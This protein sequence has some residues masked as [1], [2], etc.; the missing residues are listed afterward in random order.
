M[1]Q[2]QIPLP[3][4]AHICHYRVLYGDT[5]SGGV[6][7]YANYLRFFELSRTELMRDAGCTYRSL[8]EQ[9]M[10]LPVVESYVRYKASARYDDMLTIRTA[11]IELRKF[12]CRFN[13]AITR[14]ADD[15]LLVK[16]FTVHA[17][18]NREGSLTQFSPP[19]Y[20]LL[21]ATCLCPSNPR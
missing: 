18:V 4:Q 11:M 13:Y 9:G 17:V 2:I 14:E 1:T 12:S 15:K 21:T 10:I 8:E 20:S 7:Y 6:V 19:V 5:D 16:G 3:D